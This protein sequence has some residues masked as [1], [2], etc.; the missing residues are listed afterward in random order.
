MTCWQREQ[1]KQLLGRPLPRTFDP[2]RRL[3]MVTPGTG[4]RIATP[5]VLVDT[6]PSNV[7]PSVLCNLLWKPSLS[8]MSRGLCH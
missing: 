6:M 7:G 2:P 8:L 3:Q 1:V 4:L 5:P